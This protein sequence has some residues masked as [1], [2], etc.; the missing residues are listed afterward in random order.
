VFLDGWEG[1]PWTVSLAVGWLFVV[2]VQLD[3][4]SSAKQIPFLSQI[5]GVLYQHGTK[6]IASQPS[7][8]T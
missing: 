4:G 7:Q 6:T 2:W 8:F 3:F 5:C 1:D